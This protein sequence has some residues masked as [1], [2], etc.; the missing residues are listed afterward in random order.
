MKPWFL[1][2]EGFF[3]LNFSFSESLDYEFPFSPEPF[4]EFRVPRD[5][6]CT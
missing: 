3:F 6:T 2:L 1:C 5:V 4:L